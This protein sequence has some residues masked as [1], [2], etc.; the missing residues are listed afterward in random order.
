MKVARTQPPPGVR[1]ARGGAG[2]P[3]SAHTPGPGSRTPGGGAGP[4][5]SVPA[6]T[7]RASG[8][9]GRGAR[10]CCDAGADPGR[11]ARTH[12]GR[13]PLAHPL[14]YLDQEGVESLPVDREVDLERRLEGRELL[15]GS[16]PGD[17][18]GDDSAPRGTPRQAC[19][20]RRDPGSAPAAWR[21]RRAPRARRARPSR[22]GGAGRSPPNRIKQLQCS[23]SWGRRERSSVAGFR[24]RRSLVLDDLVVA[25]APR[26]R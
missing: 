5:A 8:R 20:G 19:P 16:P 2:R 25:I 14:I 3:R 4:R 26:A 1:P 12:A 7:H 11:S 24:E 18:G 9:G 10:G 6:T 22:G 21:R 23:G 15:P 13:V 17:G